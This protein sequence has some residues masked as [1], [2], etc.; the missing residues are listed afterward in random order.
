MLWASE[1]NRM[2]EV[3]HCLDCGHTQDVSIQDLINQRKGL[4]GPK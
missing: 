1:Y 2:V 3:G 4:P